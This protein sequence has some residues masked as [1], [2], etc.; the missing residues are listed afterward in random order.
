M[1]KL[2][3]PPPP[4]TPIGFMGGPNG[5]PVYAANDWALYWTVGIMQRLGGYNAPSITELAALI[6]ALDLRVDALEAAIEDLSSWTEAEVDL[7]SS[8]VY[9]T[10]FVIED[11]RITVDT[12][13]RIMPSAKPATGRTSDDWAWDAASFAAEPGDGQATVYATFIPGPVV[14]PRMVQYSIG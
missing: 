12:P 11:E 1:S 6:A 14:G 4:R 13:V 7:G 9:S 2:I 3:P 8:P 10:T 5:Q